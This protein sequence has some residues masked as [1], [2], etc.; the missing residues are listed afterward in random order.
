MKA[1]KI[2]ITLLVVVFTLSVLLAAVACTPTPPPTNNKK[3]DDEEEEE[4]DLGEMLNTEVGTVVDVVDNTLKTALA[5]TNTAHVGATLF[6]NVHMGAVAAVP[7]QGTTPAKPA[8]PAIDL[9]L[10]IKV[11]A[12]FDS[13]NAHNNAVLI[14]IKDTSKEGLGVIASIFA[15]NS[16]DK[17]YVYIGQQAWSSKF[18]WVRFRQ[19]ETAG[20]LAGTVADKVF[21]LLN[22]IY[23]ANKTDIDAGLVNGKVGSILTFVPMIAPLGIIVPTTPEVT[24]AGF[25]VTKDTAKYAETK[26]AG[27]TEL[28]LKVEELGA[29]LDVAPLLGLDFGDGTEAKPGLKATLEEAGLFGLVDI[30]VGAIL[31]QSYTDLFINKA[32]TEG[33]LYPTIGIGIGH[34]G[35]ALKGIGLHYDYTNNPELPLKLDLGIKNLIVSSQAVDTVRPSVTTPNFANA[36]E[37]A[38]EVTMDVV[39]DGGEVDSTI[40]VV[41][42]PDIQISLVNYKDSENNIVPFVDIDFV[43]LKGYA[44]IMDNTAT[45]PAAVTFAKFTQDNPETELEETIGFLLE[46]EPVLSALK[47]ETTG[48]SKAELNYFIPLDAAKM[49]TDYMAA[50]KEGFTPVAN[51]SIV[52]QIMAKVD[53]SFADGFAIG[54]ILSFID[55]VGPITE[56]MNGL[57]GVGKPILA[58]AFADGDR[59]AG[60]AI[61]IAALMDALL[62]KE[63][64][65]IA[66]TERFEFTT[67]YD[68][69][70]TVFTDPEEESLA[71]YLAPTKVIDSVVTFMNYNTG[72]AQADEV[73]ATEYATEHPEATL[74]EI[75]AAIEASKALYFDDISGNETGWQLAQIPLADLFTED[76]AIR[77]FAAVTGKTLSASDAY[78]GLSLEAFVSLGA[79]K[80]TTSEGI[81]LS[82]ELKDGEETAVKVAINLN[83][84]GT[85]DRYIPTDIGWQEEYTDTSLDD[86]AS[87]KKFLLDRVM[88]F[89]IVEQPVV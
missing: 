29:I 59:S 44:T 23:A 83:I 70:G 76:D 30:L 11:E 34:D 55:F 26:V 3:D 27:G 84:I 9:D 79:S 10:E 43:E 66:K 41:A 75:N 22:G 72:V 85:A 45:T 71:Y 54:D 8:I 1:R 36:K 47:L 42:F 16:S 2:I 65:I 60:V 13:V 40:K 50:G 86:G 64:G 57:V 31:G 17:E 62:A 58:D 67:Y 37:A 74:E 4:F 61:D 48:Y 28:A 68:K 18:E 77:I 33:V 35:N 39:L 81:S 12:S 7:A 56:A 78:D 38:V 80:R 21:E 15:L 32:S 20:L 24:E 89:A 19:A 53:T 5:V 46:L 52:D 6:A 25:S 69:D 87:L 82:I 51:A 88:E 63:D 49:F 73:F 14:E